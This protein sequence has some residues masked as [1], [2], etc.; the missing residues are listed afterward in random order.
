MTEKT[1]HINGID[2][3]VRYCAATETGFERIADKSIGEIDFSKQDDLLKLSIAAVIAAYQ[4]K[5]E[6]PPI[7]TDTLLYDATPKELGELFVGVIELRAAWYGI[8]KVVHEDTSEGGQ[9]KNG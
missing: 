8:P 6:E 7:T 1:I 9:Q 5:G 2:V 3:D 4:R